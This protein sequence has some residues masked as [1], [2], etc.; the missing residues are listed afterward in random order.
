VAGLNA[1]AQG[2]VHGSLEA[3]FEADG[4]LELRTRSPLELRGP[5]ARD[6]GPALYYL[7]NVTAGIFANDRYEVALVTQPGTRVQVASPSATRAY[8]AEAP[9]CVST[10]VEALPG[11]HL[12]WGPHATILQ[13]G[14]N[15]IQRTS[16][17]VHEGASLIAAEVLSFGRLASGERLT[18]SSYESEVT[19]E[20]AERGLQYEERYLLQPD[21]ALEAA[22]GGH[23]ALV[24]VYALGYDAVPELLSACPGASYAGSSALPNGAGFVVKALVASVSSGLAVCEAVLAGLWAVTDMSAEPVTP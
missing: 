9:A 15:L 17:V 23:G 22:L 5:F 20:S 1:L 6:D 12:V 18:F 24:C 16:V 13:A 8:I 7:R 19:V 3:R 2:G 10:R 14:A 4:R 11:S 21:G